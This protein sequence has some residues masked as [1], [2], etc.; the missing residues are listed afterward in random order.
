[1]FRDTALISRDELNL[2]TIHGSTTVATVGYSDLQYQGVQTVD[3]LNEL[4][5]EQL[6]A[7]ALK[8]RKSGQVLYT[9]TMITVPNSD[10]GN[11]LLDC[12]RPHADQTIVCAGRVYQRRD[13]TGIKREN[14]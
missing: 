13:L 12:Y 10:E 11:A 5:R 2:G 14:R 1:M 8:E 9:R 6:I 3:P 4:S 7:H